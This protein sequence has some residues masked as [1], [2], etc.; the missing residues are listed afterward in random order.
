MLHLTDE[1]NVKRRDKY[2]ALSS[3]SMY[4]TWKNIKKSYKINKYK[5]SAPTWNENVELA[6]GPCSVSDA[7][8]ILSTWSETWNIDR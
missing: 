1:T 5:V 6:D 8:V 2:V 4:Y 7:K 3:L